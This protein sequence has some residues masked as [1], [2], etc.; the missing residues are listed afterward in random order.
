MAVRALYTTL[1]ELGY[2]R[3]SKLGLGIMDLI[4]VVD[5]GGSSCRLGVFDRSGSRLTQTT[6]D[7]AAQLSSDVEQAWSSVCKG[8]QQLA[9]ELDLPQT[10]QPSALCLGLAGAL[11]KQARAEFLSQL[12]KKTQFK[13]FT[14]GYAQLIGA[15]GNA[16]GVCLSV[17]TGSVVHW[18]DE[19]GQSG[20]A[21]G[22]GF[23]AGDEG[24][25][26]WLG[27]A[28]LN[29]FCKHN[30]RLKVLKISR[31]SERESALETEDTLSLFSQ[32]QK[33]IQSGQTNF[34]VSQ[35]QQWTTLKDPGRL[36][37]LAPLVS[38]AADSGDKDAIALLEE[39]V[40]H[41]K[42]L[43]DFAPQHLSVYL[44]GGLSDF[45]RQRLQTATGRECAF[46]AGDALDGLL[47][48]YRSEESGLT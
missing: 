16:P 32:L 15:S 24:S 35:L 25:G 12:P 4:V 44:V 3:F 36:A 17:G 10:W 46:P 8:F 19:Q 45:Y 39:G 21:G 48:L 6:V 2:N 13:L 22:W 14:D 27:L 30:D 47:H 7:G 9:G 18:K 33:T 29:R 26:A 11:Q 5:G 41:L 1:S 40:L 38:A 34:S 23:P 42:Q 43:L 31:V 28:L 20:M 37:T